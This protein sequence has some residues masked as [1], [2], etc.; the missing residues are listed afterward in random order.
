MKYSATRIEISPELNELLEQHIQKL[1]EKTG[2]SHTKKKVLAQLC[3]AGLEYQKFMKSHGPVNQSVQGMDQAASE[4]QSIETIR[5]INAIQ[6]ALMKKEKRLL[7]KEKHLDEKAD[8]INEIHLSIL[9]LREEATEMKI[10]SLNYNSRRS[11]DDQQIK[12]LDRT[13][14]DFKR[15]INND[16]RQM[17]RLLR[18]IQSNTKKEF[19][20]YPTYLKQD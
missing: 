19:L 4:D 1:K 12:D 7:K 10:N 15:E 11:S 14:E 18:E 13:I 17:N 6:D 16:H 20:Y 8:R 9:R 3:Q 2:K 5:E